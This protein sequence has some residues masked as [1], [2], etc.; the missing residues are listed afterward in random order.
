VTVQRL[1]LI[2]LTLILARLAIWK[3]SLLE[4]LFPSNSPWLSLETYAHSLPL[5]GNL[6]E[7]LVS[8]TT[9][10]LLWKSVQHFLQQAYPF[11]RSGTARHQ[12]HRKD[13]PGIGLCLLLPIGLG[14]GLSLL[15]KLSW[16]LIQDSSIIPFSAFQTLPSLPEFGLHAAL[17]LATLILLASFEISWRILN[18]FL[19]PILPGYPLLPPLAGSILILLGVGLPLPSAPTDE[20]HFLTRGVVA[21]CLLL[22]TLTHWTRKTSIPRQNEILR[23]FLITGCILA[24]FSWQYERALD[25][26][27]RQHA[28][29]RI[30]SASEATLGKQIELG[31][32]RI[33]SHPETVSRLLDG[34]DRNDPDLAFRIWSQSQLAEMG[35]DCH[36]SIFAENP[37]RTVSSFWQ[38][39]PPF[40]WY[41]SLLMR[42]VESDR[43]LSFPG[44]NRGKNTQFFVGARRVQDPANPARHCYLDLVVPNLTNEFYRGV[45]LPKLLGGKDPKHSLLVSPT[46]SEYSRDGSLLRTTAEDLP[47]SPH[48]PKKQI[49]DLV[50][51]EERIAADAYHILNENLSGR[52]YRT[53]YVPLERNG[54]IDR[55]WAIRVDKGFQIRSE[56]RSL[57]FLLLIILILLFSRTLVPACRWLTDK[58]R[59]F[60]PHFTLEGKLVLS[61]LFIAALPTLLVGFSIRDEAHDNI[62]KEMEREISL[63]LNS[64]QKTLLEEGILIPTSSNSPTSPSMRFLP[65]SER[66]HAIDGQFPNLSQLPPDMDHL[67]IEMGRRLDTIILVYGPE[68]SISS[69]RPELINSGLLPHRL[70]PEVRRARQEEG[71]QTV[72][73]FEKVQG[74]PILFGYRIQTDPQ[75]RLVG[76]IAIPALFRQHELDRTLTA[77]SDRILTSTVG[78]ILAMILVAST[79]AHWMTRPIRI[80]LDGTTRVAGGNLDI[81]L[82]RQSND[83]LGDL[84]E[85]FNRMTRDLKESQEKLVHAEKEAT[86]RDMAKQ[87]AHEIKN[88]LTPMKLSTQH[89]V[90]AYQKS[91]ETFDATLQKISHTLIEQID[92]LNRIA[93]GFGD[94]ARFPERDLISLDIAPLL[95]ETLD[96]LHPPEGP[97]IQKILDLAPDL[98]E[99]RLDRDETRRVFINLITNAYQ[100]MEETGG[101]LRITAR[102]VSLP[103]ALESHRFRCLEGDPELEPNEQGVRIDFEDTGSGIEEAFLKKIFIP[104]FSTKSQGSG[105]GLAMCKKSVV[106]MGGLIGV[107]SKPSEGTTFTLLFRLDAEGA[108]T[109]VRKILEEERSRLER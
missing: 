76:A 77:T 33:T 37:V 56:F 45:V 11:P 73:R 59:R 66:T 7:L 29:P 6:G 47:R 79:L 16:S 44:A 36:F 101:T 88:P 20:T 69:N 93:T 91:P 97:R 51:S 28:G 5:V 17:V 41:Q 40:D 67:L 100:A 68:S 19:I 98:P 48:L 55:I 107:Q 14:A 99:V 105:L 9:I 49:D 1:I 21:L 106:E 58:N 24:L 42:L 46:Y 43:I 38:N 72:Y 81:H 94:F 63:K 74:E 57:T 65:P 13:L 30:Y 8:L 27:L 23:V 26:E 87:V 50:G 31:L 10:L 54:T 75:G 95:K 84:V 108:T 71:R 89:L 61:F 78:I 104:S 85:S 34:V 96:V 109:R 53:L 92:V 18:R 64:I 22:A 15:E 102:A 3:F 12:P 60:R 86:W 82:P 52:T 4:F 25:L 83:E 70:P 39:M 35:L 32:E 80:L 2:G 103:G 62:I 90:R